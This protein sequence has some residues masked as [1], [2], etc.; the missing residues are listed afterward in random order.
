MEKK[1]VAEQ[2]D[3]GLAVYRLENVYHMPV[4]Q[5]WTRLPTALSAF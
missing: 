3:R 5:G 1:K 2:H 4:F